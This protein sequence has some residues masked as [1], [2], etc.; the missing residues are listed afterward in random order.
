MG[1]WQDLNNVAGQAGDAWRKAPPWLQ[2]IVGIIPFGDGIDL[3]IEAH[4]QANGRKADPVVVTLSALGLAADA[5]TL[6]GIGAGFNASLSMVKVAY[7]SMGAIGKEAMQRVFAKAAQD[8]KTMQRLLDTLVEL[9]KDGTL[10]RL[11]QDFR[12]LPKVLETGIIRGGKFAA[13]QIKSLYLGNKDFE[14]SEDPK[15]ISVSN[16]VDKNSEQQ[17]LLD[18]INENKASFE[19][20]GVDISDPAQLKA[21]MEAI[22]K[23]MENAISNSQQL[24]P[25]G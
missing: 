21:V 20:N 8:P 3:A 23:S 4:R 16:T 22:Q 2:G 10:V 14:K 7:N 19:S 24:V 12:N 11:T 5:A 9:A 13:H 15:Y 1:I 6:T 18:T 17:L 25:G